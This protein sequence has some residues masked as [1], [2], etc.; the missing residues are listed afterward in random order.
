MQHS[1]FILCVVWN[2]TWG[3]YWSTQ[4]LCAFTAHAWAD[5]FVHAWADCQLFGRVELKAAGVS[6]F[7]QDCDVFWNCASCKAFSIQ[8]QIQ[9]RSLSGFVRLCH[10]FLASWNTTS[11]EIITSIINKLMF[12]RI[13]QS[14]IHPPFSP[15]RKVQWPGRQLS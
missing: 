5:G 10:V 3:W 7:R 13:D 4:L 8:S 1:A 14:T 2:E 12:L 11:A 9:S 15:Y 6:L